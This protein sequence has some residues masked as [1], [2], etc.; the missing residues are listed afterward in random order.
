MTNN[1]DW[2]AGPLDRSFNFLDEPIGI[3]FLGRSKP[4]WT[5]TAKARQGGS[6]VLFRFQGKCG[7]EWSPKMRCIRHTMHEQN[8]LQTE[9]LLLVFA[10]SSEMIC[11][12]PVYPLIARLLYFRVSAVSF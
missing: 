5:R 3:A 2:S 8:M 1:M 11:P 12:R 7:N 6:G 4:L 9:V 10:R